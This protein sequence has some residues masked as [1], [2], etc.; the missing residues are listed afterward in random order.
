M[1]VGG[2]LPVF[3]SSSGAIINPQFHQYVADVIL[4]RKDTDAKSLGDIDVPLALGDQLKN[5]NLSFA[6]L[7][8]QVIF[9]LISMKI[10]AKILGN[11]YCTR[12]RSPFWSSFWRKFVKMK[13]ISGRETKNN[14]PDQ[15]M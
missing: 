13:R 9:P 12:Q 11:R 3:A 7:V 4:N 2:L 1:L 15:S 14:L 6:Q 8:Y 5:L 10:A